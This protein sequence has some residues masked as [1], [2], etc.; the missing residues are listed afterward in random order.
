MIS[1]AVLCQMKGSGSWFQCS[2]QISMASMR[3]ATLVN[4]PLRRR[5][6]VSSLNQRSMMFSQDEL[7]GVKCRCQQVPATPFGVGQPVGDLGTH[8]G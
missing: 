1:S 7:V 2:A 6:S 5:R 3:S 8:V 4:T